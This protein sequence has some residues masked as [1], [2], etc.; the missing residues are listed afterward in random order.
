MTMDEAMATALRK[1]FGYVP[2]ERG[3]ERWV[4]FQGHTLIVIHPE[5]RPRLYKDGCGG[6]HYAIEPVFP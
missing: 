5:E 6:L 1:K 3:G 4:V 2:N